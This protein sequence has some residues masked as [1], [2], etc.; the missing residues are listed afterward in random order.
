M[1]VVCAVASFKN[2]GLS[3]KW[4]RAINENGSIGKWQ[5]AVSKRAGGNSGSE[6]Q[7]I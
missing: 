1:N 2:G 7:T 6:L 3:D 4:I 5:W